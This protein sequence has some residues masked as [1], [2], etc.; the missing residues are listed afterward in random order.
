MKRMKM[1]KTIISLGVFMSLMLAFPMS[2]FAGAQDFTVEN[3]TGFD[4]HQLYVAPMDAKDWQED[5][6]GEAL[7]ANNDSADIIFDKAETAPTWALKMVDVNEN[8][9]EWDNLDLLKI[10]K[11]KLTYD[12]T[13]AYSEVETTDDAAA[14]DVAATDATDVAAT[15]AT[16]AAATDAT[17]AAATDEAATDAV[18]E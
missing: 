1:K 13:N 10:T 4:I 6:L 9:Y 3:A 16:D 8:S 2:A 7:L 11:V 17:D 15:D 12:G 18:A 14:T 5:I